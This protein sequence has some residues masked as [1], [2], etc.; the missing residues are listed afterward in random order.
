MIRVHKFPIE[1]LGQQVIK[2]PVGSEILN[3]AMQQRHSF[4]GE[5]PVMWAKVN[6][7]SKIEEVT[8]HVRYTGA[9]IEAGFQYLGTV[10]HDR[11][12]YHIFKA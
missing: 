5:Q 8:I 11:L 3:V 1:F 9:E 7:E 6:T 2:M 10:V 12:V 4:F